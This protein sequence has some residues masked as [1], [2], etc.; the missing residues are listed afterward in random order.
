VKKLKRFFRGCLS[1]V[2][3]IAY[4]LASLVI[5]FG[6]L[7]ILI[8]FGS[9][10]S[11]IMRKII[12]VAY[13]AFVWAGEALKLFKVNVDAETFEKIKTA[14]GLVV[15]ANHP[16]LIDIV[17]LTALL[18]ESTGFAKAAAARNFFYSRVV[19]SIF[20][21]NEN[22]EE[23]FNEALNAIRKGLNVIIFPQGTRTKLDEERKL[24]RGAANISLRS[25]AP[26]LPLRIKMNIPVLGKNQPWYNVGEETVVYTL[27]ADEI[28]YPGSEVSRSAAV[29]LT[30]RIGKAIKA[31]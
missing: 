21:P 29:E 27:E 1:S 17:I 3:F 19:R 30:S 8:L 24:H 28:I 12:R 15:V 4:G 20:I 16:S 2:F 9:R 6:V 26:V 11:H 14:K 31:T 25:N 18:P 7:P 10:V 13:R 22:P 23:A 5:G